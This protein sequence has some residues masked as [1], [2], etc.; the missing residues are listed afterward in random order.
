MII[1]ILVATVHI[2]GSICTFLVITAV[3]V[4]YR[5]KKTIEEGE[6]TADLVA[7]ELGI[8][9]ENRNDD[10]HFM[11]MF[12]HFSAFWS[13]E[14]F[15]NRLADLFGSVGVAL[16]LL[17]SILIFLLF[18]WL[19]Y[20]TFEDGLSSAPTWW[21]LVLTSVLFSLI[22]AILN[23]LCKLITGCAPGLPKTQRATLHQ[24]LNA[25]EERQRS[26]I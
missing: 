15:L 24:A 1:D 4:V 10:A 22:G 13:S 20:L 17:S 8:P 11:Q 5:N 3:S 7:A 16:K 18:L 21:L 14:K 25:Y 9:A 19:I 6:K 26:G 2:L 23:G 12:A